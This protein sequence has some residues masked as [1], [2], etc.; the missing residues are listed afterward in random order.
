MVYRFP[1]TILEAES[2]RLRAW[3]VVVE[4][5]VRY[6]AGFLPAWVPGLAA[7]RA[8]HSKQAVPAH[9]PPYITATGHRAD[10]TDSGHY[11]GPARKS[12][13]LGQRHADVHLVFQVSSCPFLVS[14]STQKKKKKEK[15]CGCLCSSSG[16]QG[17]RS[18]TRPVLFSEG[19]MN[20]FN[21][22]EER[23]WVKSFCFI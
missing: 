2:P 3:M 7:H 20:W 23:A 18:A 16:G 21:Y 6:R 14:S 15:E 8:T 5:Q 10:S 4:Q 1:N 9:W 17:K 11:Y 19:R 12:L 22:S 13:H